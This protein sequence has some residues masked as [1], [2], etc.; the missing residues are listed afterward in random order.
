M[1][2]SVESFVEAPTLSSLT[3]LK[4]SELLADN[5]WNEKE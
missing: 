1:S 2:F 4:K 3:L 5:Q